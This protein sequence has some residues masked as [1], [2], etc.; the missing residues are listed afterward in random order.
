[1]GI[2]LINESQ[3]VIYIEM[4]L[5]CVVRFGATST[6]ALRVIIRKIKLFIWDNYQIEVI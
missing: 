4:P 5:F 3:N 6:V 2:E 1:M